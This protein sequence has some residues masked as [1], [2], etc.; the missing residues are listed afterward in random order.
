VTILAARRRSC[1]PTTTDSLGNVLTGRA[2]TWASNNSAVTVNGN[3]LVTG[4]GSGSA[5][6]TATSEGKS[7]TAT[8]TVTTVPVASVTVTPASANLQTGQTVQLTATARDASGNPLSGRV[9]T[10]TSTN[11]SIATVNGSGLGQR[12]RGRLGHDHGD[13]EGTERLRRASR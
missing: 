13:D 4:A 10:W 3:G 6:I 12:H 9:M 8:V 2:V 5:T 11:T 1:K 7:G